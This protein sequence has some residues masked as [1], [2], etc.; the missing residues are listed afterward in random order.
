MLKKGEKQ[1]RPKS[2]HLNEKNFF[3]CQQFYVSAVYVSAV[4]KLL[5]FTVCVSSF[6]KS[7]FVCN[8]EPKL[9][10]FDKLFLL[11]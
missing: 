7:L 11:K 9:G 3:M 2:R 4:K 10:H 6:Q 8:P 5:N 1:T